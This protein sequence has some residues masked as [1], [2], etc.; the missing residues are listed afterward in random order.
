[1][2][3]YLIIV[4]LVGVWNCEDD[5]EETTLKISFPEG[6]PHPILYG[7]CRVIK[8]GGD[9]DSGSL[10]LLADS[11]V[12]LDIPSGGIYYFD[13]MVVYANDRPGFSWNDTNNLTEGTNN[14]FALPCL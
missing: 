9:Y 6:C 3:K 11:S 7:Y 12:T 10:Y 1:M 4:L 14:S 5:N 8:A 13:G 2:K